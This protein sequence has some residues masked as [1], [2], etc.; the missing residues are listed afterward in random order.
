MRECW[1]CRYYSYLINRDWRF[2][3]RARTVWHD[4]SEILGRCVIRVFRVIA[5]AWQV[6]TAEEYAPVLKQW[7][8]DE[9][10]ITQA[11]ESELSDR[12]RK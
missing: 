1:C 5:N 10:S 4:P 8:T 6:M 11:H 3:G 2:Q 7:N 12:K 9:A